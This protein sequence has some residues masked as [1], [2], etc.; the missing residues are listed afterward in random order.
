MTFTQRRTTLPVALSAFVLL[1]AGR[2]GAQG[3]PA[4]GTSAQGTTS[5]DATST[6][7]PASPEGEKP[8]EAAAPPQ[9]VPMPDLH[10]N[11]LGASDHASH[12]AATS[13]PLPPRRERRFFPHKATPIGRAGPDFEPGDVLPGKLKV[14]PYG[15]IKGDIFWEVGS[16]NRSGL[17]S[18][19]VPTF[20]VVL[21]PNSVVNVYGASARKTRFGL[22]V[23]WPTPPSFFKATSIDAKVEI[24][25]FGG[26][27]GQSVFSYF[28]IPRLRFAYAAVSWG[29]TRLV[30]GQDN[31]IIAPQ[32]PES[33]F[34]IITQPLG[35]SG[36]LFGR[37][38]QVRLEGSTKGKVSFIWAGGLL[39]NIQSDGLNL[40]DP[41]T[42]ALFRQ[43][44]GGELAVSPAV[45]G[46]IGIAGKAWGD[47]PWTVGISGHY[48]R[49][50][51]RVFDATTG[52]P[53]STRGTNGWAGAFDV[54]VPL[55]RTLV[56][57][58][59]VWVGDELEAYTGGS[60]Q[61]LRVT[62]NA[63]GLVTGVGGAIRSMG[64]WGMINFNPIPWLQ[65]GSVF[66][67]DN[68][69][70][71]TLPALPT[72]SRAR[73]MTLYEWVSVEVAK[74]YLIGFEYDY[75]HTNQRSGLVLGSH[76]Y[77]VNGL[78]YF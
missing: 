45:Q 5:Q 9:P 38:P 34:R 19:D 78:L 58:G 15:V 57:K 77:S 14:T 48:A 31:I 27:F 39:A 8:P 41:T 18:F 1:A 4:Q 44:Q 24:D 50:R 52:A 37:F 62:R 2:A 40:P 13:S 56:L 17:N 10:P 16:N 35:A 67:A 28:S 3:A 11:A 36:N 60:N 7:P 76:I 33:L 47:K 63:A 25:F 66:G 54:Q 20:G 59:E 69:I 26:V 71:S 74:G 42:F 32:I 12:H 72:D 73:V 51:T 55:H 68:P 43:P 30:F 49:R 22:H 70:D 21:P 6:T 61:G 29:R 23:L 75:I 64:G 53:N 46:H 65:I